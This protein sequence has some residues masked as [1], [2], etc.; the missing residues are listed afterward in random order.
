MHCMMHLYIPEYCLVRLHFNFLLWPMIQ[1]CPKE[2]QTHWCQIFSGMSERTWGHV[3]NQYKLCNCYLVRLRH[4]CRNLWGCNLYS[5]FIELWYLNYLF[6]AFIVYK[7]YILVC[8]RDRQLK[9]SPKEFK[10]RHVWW[11]RV[12]GMGWWTWGSNAHKQ[13][14]LCCWYFGS[15][16]PSL[17]QIMRS[18]IY[19]HMELHI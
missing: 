12:L 18:L 6:H 1:I 4:L 9:F 15:P 14:R 11:C 7:N 5:T 3:Q 16:T 2:R 19:S 8:H 10:G 13:Y 17:K